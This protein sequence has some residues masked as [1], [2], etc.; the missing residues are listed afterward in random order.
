MFFV[1]RFPARAARGGFG[2][3]VGA[4]ERGG[5]RKGSVVGN[6]DERL[7]SS[8]L[9]W[10]TSMAESSSPS[11]HDVEILLRNAE[12]WERL[13]PYLDESIGCV[14]LRQSPTAVENDYLASML[15]WEEAPILP[16]SM[17][18]EPELRLPD[19]QDL[20]RE[21][22]RELLWR[23][24]HR[25]YEKR[26]VLDFTDHLS[27]R[28]LY[29]LIRRDILA[30]REKKIEPVC[31]YLHWDCSNAAADP[32]LWLRYYA[33]ADERLAWARETGEAPPPPERPPYPRSLPRRPL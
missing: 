18:F 24:I 25:L 2:R 10:F 8:K 7:R 26:I 15:A 21:Q 32:Y 4:A 30:S 17:W 20:T 31:T 28:A 13:E 3:L 33:T 1:G 5:L 9:I 6:S 11:L 27:D 19:S 14:N 29:E 22:L 23:T 12:L 16:I